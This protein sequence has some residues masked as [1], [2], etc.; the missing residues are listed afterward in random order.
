V[1]SFTVRA[2]WSKQVAPYATIISIAEYRPTGSKNATRSTITPLATP[3]R[4]KGGHQSDIAALLGKMSIN[5][6]KA[7]EAP[8]AVPFTTPITPVGLTYLP[9]T[10]TGFGFPVGFALPANNMYSPT[11]MGTMGG[12]GA[13][14]MGTMLTQMTPQSTY[15]MAGSMTG[16]SPFGSYAGQGPSP[17]VFSRPEFGRPM[18]HQPFVTD[19]PHYGSTSSG[20][21]H[22]AGYSPR[23][24]GPVRRQNAVK[25]PYH[26]AATYRRNQQNTSGG[27]HNF[28]DIDNIYLG[29]DV[30]TTVSFYQRLSRRMILTALGYVA[31]Y[32]KQGHAGRVKEVR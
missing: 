30:R 9:T 16:F 12:M 18:G 31:E 27:N 20:P 11:S 5:K 2:D 10:N 22:P 32:S 15:P 4:Q 8:Q 29:V 6:G 19:H 13:M 3:T 7:P 21:S 17:N 23:P 26:I 25:V 28:V 24:M 1:F 14:G